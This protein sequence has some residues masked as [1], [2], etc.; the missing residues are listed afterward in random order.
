ME[1]V[2]RRNAGPGGVKAKTPRPRAARRPACLACQ[3]NKLRCSGGPHECDR[4]QD[5][6]I[7][8]VFAPTARRG[9]PRTAAVVHAE[10]RRSQSLGPVADDTPAQPSS[11]RAS[12]PEETAAS[13]QVQGDF[14]GSDSDFSGFGWLLPASPRQS[15][16]GLCTTVPMVEGGPTGSL[17]LDESLGC[18]VNRRQF[19]P[20]DSLGSYIA[21]ALGESHTL[22]QGQPHH[23]NQETPIQTETPSTGSTSQTKPYTP[24]CSCLE[25]L[26]R[27]IQQFADDR[28]HLT[29]LS[30]DQVLQIKKWVVFQCCAP[31]DCSR[32]ICPNSVHTMLLIICDRLTEMF[33]CIHKR[34][35]RSTSAMTGLPLGDLSIQP[36]TTPSTDSLARSPVPVLTSTPFF[37]SADDGLPPR[38]PQIFC[39]N[40]KGPA[41]LA[42]CSSRLFSDEFRSQYSDEEQVHIIRVLLKLQVRNFRQ[43]L[44]R[45]ERSTQTQESLARKYTVESMMG[46][47]AKSSADIDEA[48]HQVLQAISATPMLDHV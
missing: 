11:S 36:A 24:N 19:S 21:A 2:A 17:G 29:S 9:S 1:Q 23:D 6:D 30:L 34:I 12:H 39:A 15:S 43:L 22:P 46:R 28:F 47:I 35:K 40:S 31:L 18:Q 26:M 4:C 33:E 45:V 8:C 42:S 44:V 5:R 3:R 16:S 38:P 20:T 41:Y 27:I 7:D 13:D 10:S 14:V 48:M 32:C 25:D 37:S